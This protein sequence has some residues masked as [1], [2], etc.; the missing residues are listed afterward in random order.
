MYVHI[1]CKF[2]SKLNF[3][4]QHF[5]SLD[6]PTEEYPDPCDAITGELRPARRRIQYANA[7]PIQRYI[8]S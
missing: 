4:F 3:I 2:V 7:T 5:I 8:M 6:G 1:Y